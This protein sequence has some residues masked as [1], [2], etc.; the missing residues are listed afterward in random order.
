M[1]EATTTLTRAGCTPANDPVLP[2]TLLK[3]PA[4]KR[5]FAESEAY[6]CFRAKPTARVSRQ[7]AAKQTS[8][9]PYLSSDSYWHSSQAKLLRA[10]SFFSAVKNM[11]ARRHLDAS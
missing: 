6:A 4:E 5:S 8:P 3:L 1:T 2:F 10:A 11:P 9:L 7:S